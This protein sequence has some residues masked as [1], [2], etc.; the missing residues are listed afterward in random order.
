MSA[1]HAAD[2]RI[3][4]TRRVG[5]KRR[6]AVLASDAALVQALEANG[7]TVLVDPASLDELSAFLPEVVVAFDGFALADGN[8]AFRTLAAAAGQAELV[9]SFANT[10]SASSLLGALTNSTPP[11]SLA[12]P[13]VRRWLSSAGY[14]IAGREIVVTSHRPSSLSA[15]TEAALRQLLE[16]VNPDAAAERLVLFAKRGIAASVP[17]RTPSLVSMVVSSSDDESKLAGTLSSLVN[18]QRRPLEL[19][20]VANMPA[21]RLERLLEKPRARSGVTVVALTSISTEES[22]R[23]NAGLVVAQGQYLAFTEAGTLFSPT[24]LSTLVKQLEDGTTAWAL[25][26]SSVGGAKAADRA[27]AFSLAQWLKHGWVSRSE[28]LLDTSRLGPFPVTFAEGVSS[29]EALFFVRLSLLFSPSWRPGPSSVECLSGATLELP[30][31]LESMRGRPLRGLVT[32]EE[33]LRSPK[34][35]TFDEWVGAVAD[36]IRVAWSDARKATKRE[37]EKKE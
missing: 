8:E 21:Q 25:G 27:R 23:T 14:V 20:V 10:S 5:L 6:V 31:L 1:Q 29:F 35:P 30:T 26:T 19:I 15:D 7:C 13:D 4:I 32:F 3:L 2:L 33:L 28:W 11:P 18:Q 24:H 36:R 37:L 17:E 16:Q 22:I 12:E 34:K 9:F